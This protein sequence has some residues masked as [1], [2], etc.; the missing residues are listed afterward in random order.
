MILKRILYILKLIIFSNYTIGVEQKIILFSN[1]KSQTNRN[2]YLKPKIQC[3][4]KF[5]LKG[6]I[7]QKKK[8]KIKPLMNCI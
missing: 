3:T 7:C 4:L 6:K 5:Y 8:K 1:Y 2:T